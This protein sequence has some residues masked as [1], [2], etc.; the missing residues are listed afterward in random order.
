MRTLPYPEQ[1]KS[2]GFKAIISS[3]R[4]RNFRLFWT[5]QCIS[6]VGTWMQNM[7]QSWLVLELT[8]S[9]FLLGLVGA[10]QFIPLLLFALFTG[11]V[12]DRLP[13]RPLLLFAQGMSMLIALVLG[14]L[15]LFNV[16]QYWHVAVLAFLLGTMHSLDMPARQAFIIELVGRDDLMNAIA[17]NSSVFNGARIIGPAVAG[18]VISTVGIA[19]CFL[20]NAASFLFVLG[21][22]LLIQVQEDKDVREGHKKLWEDVREGLAYI[23]SNPTVFTVLAMVGSM[24]TLAINFNVLVPVFAREVLHREAQGFGFL[25]SATGL[26]A[27]MGALT[28]AYLSNRGPRVKLLLAAASGFCLCELLLALVRYYPLALVLLCLAGFAVSTFSASANATVQMNIPDHLRGRVM[29]VYSLVFIGLVPLGNFFSGTVAHLWG[30]PA[31]F[32][33]GGGLALLFLL[34]LS[35]R[36]L[37]H[38]HSPVP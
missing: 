9:P 7:A 16:V 15:T 27:F 35:R 3:L 6:L 4:H 33:L 34:F 25:M 32:A 2:P 38:Q 28:L 17:L 26:G 37:R 31:G 20:A 21:G 23:R 30:A 22:L 36:L 13:K 12:V 29:S 11:V 14:L 19:A 5:G 8:G 18:L 1:K 10:L 24:S